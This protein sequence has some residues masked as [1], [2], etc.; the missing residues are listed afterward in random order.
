MIESANMRVDEFTKKISEERKKELKD[1]GTITYIE[2]PDTL[3]KQHC[4]ITEKQDNDTEHQPIQTENQET[5]T[6]EDHDPTSNEEYNEQ[7]R[8]EL[9]LAKFVRRHHPQNQ[10]IGNKKVGMMT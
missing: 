5:V 7:Q 1:Y 10:I 6:D 8:I 2:Q 3:P 9:V 4:G